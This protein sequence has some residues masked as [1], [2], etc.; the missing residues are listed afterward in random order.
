MASSSKDI[1]HEAWS[2]H[3]D[4]I[5][6]LRFDERLPLDAAKSKSRNI[7][8]VM[9][10]D[11]GFEATAAQYETQLKKWKAAKNI[12]RKDWEMILPIYEDLDNR[13]LKP[14]VRLGDQI[15]EEKKVKKARC[16][17]LTSDRAEID[18]RDVLSEFSGETRLWHIEYCHED[19][20][21]AEHFGGHLGE[22]NRQTSPQMA[23]S[24]SETNAFPSPIQDRSAQE[25]FT[26]E[27]GQYQESTANCE[28]EKFG[29]SPDHV[30]ALWASLN[31]NSMPDPGGVNPES[32][33]FSFNFWDP[34]Y[35][36]MYDIYNCVPLPAPSLYKPYLDLSK[37]QINSALGGIL[38]DPAF[39]M[40]ADTHS[41]SAQHII[42]SLQSL[43]YD[44]R[45]GQEMSRELGVVAH[46]DIPTPEI[47]KRVIFSIANNFAGLTAIPRAIVLGIL[48]SLFSKAKLDP[49]ACL[50][51]Q[52]IKISKPLADN[53]FRAAVEAGDEE[54]V[55][56]IL[57]TT[58][59]QDNVVNINEIVCEVGRMRY[60]ALSLAAYLHRPAMVRKLLRHGAKIGGDSCG[61]RNK[62]FQDCPDYWTRDCPLTVIFDQYR[63]PKYQEAY[64]KQPHLACNES[65]ATEIVK[66]IL[67]RKP[68][69][70]AR[71]LKHP[72]FFEITSDRLLELLVQAVPPGCHDEILELLSE[73]EETST[74]TCRG[75]QPFVGRLEPQ[76]AKYIVRTMLSKWQRMGRKP[77]KM[78]IAFNYVTNRAILSKQSD[79]ADYFLTITQ[80]D[81]G[82]LAAAIRGRR[83]Q[84]VDS[85]L[86]QHVS[87]IYGDPPCCDDDMSHPYISNECSKPTTPLAEAIRLQ[88][89][90]LI[91]RLEEYGALKGIENGVPEYFTAA[92]FATVEVGDC[93]YLR[94]LLATK[95]STRWI[96]GWNSA[97]VDAI[98][99]SHFEIAIALISY[100]VASWLEKESGVV[101]A[102]V[103]SGNTELVQT[104]LDLTDDFNVHKKVVMAS[105]QQGD[106]N[107]VEALLELDS[108]SLR[109]AL[110]IAVKSGNV[111]L[112][113]ML[114]KRGACPTGL[115]EA[116]QVGDL[117]LVK[118][119]LRHGADPA[120]E[121][122]FSVAIHT[123]NTQLMNI[124]LEAF[125]ARY[126]DGNQDFI[127]I[128]IFRAIKD[129]SFVDLDL[130][131]KLTSHPNRWVDSSKRCIFVEAIA[132]CGE[133][134]V[135]GNEIVRRFINA[136]VSLEFQ[137][138]YGM[139][140]FLQAVKNNN[141][142]LVEFLLQNGANI[143][144]PARWGVKRTPLQQACEMGNFEMVRFLVTRGAVINA[145]PAKD[146]GATA[147][148]LAAISGNLQIVE[149]L[150]YNGAKIHAE[151]AL[152]NGRTALEGAAEHGRV[153]VLDILLQLGA[154]EY[155]RD[156]ISK[157]KVYAEKEKQRG[158]KE[159]LEQALFG[160]RILTGTPLN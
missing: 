99:L 59:R 72:W 47:F 46:Q 11:H 96:Q 139:T 104:I 64:M 14:R 93:L 8:Q 43:L 113:A 48:K 144:R 21:Y 37:D 42:D 26:P 76:R 112:A 53:L 38:K 40:T 135:E 29:L 45:C 6:K 17:Y 50:K 12:K 51:S 122:A 152:K 147:L 62:H 66:L 100:D 90:Y 15:L 56:I 10:D 107:A 151:R 159:R 145:P 63:Q 88:D 87:L 85:L 137:D 9:K 97:I 35:P 55:G 49:V 52:S 7:V 32:L 23:L 20:T 78:N 80:P 58:S 5:L 153:S 134:E 127:Q 129:R 140:A 125:A 148:Q 28:F 77:N 155:S 115:F 24:L 154:Q 95:P 39:R 71:L 103:N 16:R 4:R 158:C 141:L 82:N 138:K 1:P 68:A 61:C 156:D 101:E 111:E 81:Q 79:V 2:R 142:Q 3:K 22:N 130:L 149:F 160:A 132:M 74:T 119:L 69:M 126:P 84:L 143:N 128:F 117:N 123:G 54:L 67:H 65:E 33:F 106:T 60:S 44:Y 131:L 146:G 73:P 136:G 94:Q 150:L 36:R 109:D 83:T 34:P 110:V 75:L 121:F 30:Y 18:G 31:G 70:V 114:L 13:G 25:S 124:L 89:P 108:Q 19:G 118:L 105:V 157:A 27:L 120:D 41:V 91:T 57:D 92:L 98:K 86:E 133:N 102:A 116:I